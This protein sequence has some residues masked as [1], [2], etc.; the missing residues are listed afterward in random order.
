[1]SQRRPSKQKSARQLK[2]GWRYTIDQWGG[3][4]VLGSVVVALLIVGTLI[5][6]NRPGAKSDPIVSTTL[7][8]RVAGRL[9][10]E[11]NAPVTIIEYA[12][13]QCPFC[14][15]WVTE[16]APALAK[17]YIATGQVQLEYRYFAF[18]GEE[19]KK[20][21]E[22]AECAADQGRFWEM[23]DVLYSH[24]AAE[25]SGVYTPSNLKKYAAEVAAKASDFDTGKFASCLDGGSKRALVDQMAAQA[26]Q[27]GVKSTPSFLVNG[28]PLIG[29]QPIEVFRTA[30]ASAKAAKP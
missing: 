24:Q 23:H 12:D 1:M 2:P 10:G 14:K 5:F 29:A 11:A 13:F 28:Q 18:L 9:H 21:A 20:A 30:I 26:A 8:G 27:V 17:E 3:F 16:T 7:E 22:A 4:P 6:L 25:N 15:K 19:S